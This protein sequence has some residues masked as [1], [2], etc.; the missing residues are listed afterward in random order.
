MLGLRYAIAYSDTFTSSV[1]FGSG[2][3]VLSAEPPSF[4]GCRSCVFTVIAMNLPIG[5]YHDCQST[6][7]GIAVPL[8]STST[9]GTV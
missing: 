6:F 9:V 3:V 8:G 4:I 7:S 2:M 1:R 5:G